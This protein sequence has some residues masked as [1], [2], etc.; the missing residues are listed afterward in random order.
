[1][2][3]TSMANFI[4]ALFFVYYILIIVRILF[5]WIG[6]PSQKQ[7]Y[8]LFRFVYDVTEPYLGLFR[9]FIPPMGGMDFSPFIAILL[10][11]VVQQ[12]VLGFI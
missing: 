5:S 3:R 4:S 8:A 12:I 11:N 9:R 1:M 2:S 6:I 10:L 7:L